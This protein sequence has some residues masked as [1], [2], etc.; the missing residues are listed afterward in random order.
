MLESGLLSSNGLLGP[1]AIP[2]TLHDS[3]MARLDRLSNARDIAQIG[4]AIGREFDYL[5]LMEVAG[6]PG[7]AISDAL[8][9]LEGAGLIFRRGAPPASSYAFKHALVQDASYNTLLRSRRQQL[10]MLIAGA[11]ERM[12]PQLIAEQPEV[13]ARHLTEPG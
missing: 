8:K 3:L 10:H 6:M 5:L 12:R 2:A 7:A 9:R 4:A 1:L 11:L 13:L